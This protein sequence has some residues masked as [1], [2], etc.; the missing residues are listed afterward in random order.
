MLIFAVII[1]VC[2]HCHHLEREGD[3]SSFTNSEGNEQ[4]VNQQSTIVEVE[5]RENARGERGLIMQQSK[6]K[7]TT[8]KVRERD[9]DA[10]D[11]NNATT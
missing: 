11:N 9:D 3:S 10:K 1:V 6:H 2:S 7:M 5:R 4:L 8:K